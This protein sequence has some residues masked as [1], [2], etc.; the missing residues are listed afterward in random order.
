M[1]PVNA[2]GWPSGATHLRAQIVSTAFGGD[3][4]QRLLDADIVEQFAQALWPEF[5]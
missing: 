2:L 5:M 4:D 3:E 1:K